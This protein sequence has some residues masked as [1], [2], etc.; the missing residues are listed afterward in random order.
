MNR[1]GKMQSGLVLL[2]AIMALNAGPFG[3]ATAKTDFFGAVP[4]DALLCVRVN[5]LDASIGALERYLTGVVPVAPLG[6]FIRMQLGNLIGDPN[7]AGIDMAGSFGV[8]ALAADADSAPQ[9]FYVLP[10]GDKQALADSPAIGKPDADGITTITPAAAGGEGA[11]VMCVVGDHVVV[12]PA[13]QSA[14][15]TGLAK[16]GAANILQAM[17][18]V[19]KA[20]AGSAPLWVRIN[21]SRVNSLYGDK[22][23]AEFQKFKDLAGMMGAAQTTNEFMD[24]YFSAIISALKQIRSIEMTLTPKDDSLALSSRLIAAPKS[25]L[26]E[27]L[28]LGPSPKGDLGLTA[29][30]KDNALANVYLRLNKPMLKKA[31]AVF[32]DLLAQSSPDARQQEVEKSRALVLK[33]LDAVGD[34]GAMSMRG[35]PLAIDNVMQVR[36]E[37]ALRDGYR[38]SAAMMSSGLWADLNRGS[39]VAMTPVYTPSVSTYKDVAID[40]FAMNIKVADPDSHEAK[41]IASMYGDDLKGSVAFVKG[42]ALMSFDKDGGEAVVK[43]LIDDVRAGGSAAAPADFKAA[44]AMVPDAA[45]ADYVATYNVLRLF[46]SLSGM[47][48][49]S[50]MAAAVAAL[51]P[52]KSSLVVAGRAAD[53]MC[54]MDIILPRQHA[55]EIMSVFLQMQ[56]SGTQDSG[57]GQI[58]QGTRRTPRRSQNKAGSGLPRT[59]AKLDR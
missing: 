18:A 32:F 52:A 51:P 40:S 3:T 7:L 17:A 11:N 39:G 14:A 44:L 24:A 29:Y 41:A 57:A 56:G 53:G 47:P 20:P 49:V 30:L 12:C 28:A 58:P 10:V 6:M 23:G 34:C 13:G 4:A 43:R 54:S 46:G 26:A 31:Y 59:P 19:E 50:G 5:N 33:F 21:M 25:K 1:P 37:K 2:A 27:I 16:P 36:D 22:L 42:L 38:E 35:M 15:L 45:N 55:L 48:G 8:F 9:F